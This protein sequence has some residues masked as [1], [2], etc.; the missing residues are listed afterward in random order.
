ML[1]RLIRFFFVVALILLSSI[2][3]PSVLSQPILTLNP[4]ASSVVEGTTITFSGMLRF[5]EQPLAGQTV[6]IKDVLSGLTFEAT[7]DSN[8]EFRFDWMAVMREESY[9]FYAE[10]SFP[11]GG[12][13]VRSEQYEVTVMPH[14]V[15][16]SAKNVNT[17]P[18]GN[19]IPYEEIATR[20]SSFPADDLFFIVLLIG[21]VA[22]AYL[23]YRSRVKSHVP[24]VEIRGGLE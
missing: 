22:G 20:D 11:A 24:I 6:T 5:N 19:E 18:A 9:G 7:T 14:S 4:V 1:D 3:T 8:G 13:F 23:I 15:N 21:A 16:E 17:E 12:T 2:S 10:F